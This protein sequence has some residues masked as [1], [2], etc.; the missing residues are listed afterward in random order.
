MSFEQVNVHPDA[1]LNGT[2]L[3]DGYQTGNNFADYLIGAPE[4]FEQADSEAYYPR[5][6]YVGW[7]AQDSW[8]VKPSLTLNYGLRVELMQYWSEK[9]DQVPTFNPGE[10]SIVY[11]QSFPGLVYATDPGIPNTSGA[12]AL[13]VRSADWHGV[14]AQ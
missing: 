9:Y 6:K 7:F 13:S 3:F 4:Q 2:F 8:R 14:F 1:T 5:H 12:G 11:P 10:Q